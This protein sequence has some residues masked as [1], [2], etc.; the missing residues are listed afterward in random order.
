MEAVSCTA[1]WTAAAR[2]L[3][4]ERSDA[5]SADPWART[6][7]GGRASTCSTATPVRGPGCT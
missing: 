3:E 6:L 5:L 2:A 4:S 7:A 1:Q